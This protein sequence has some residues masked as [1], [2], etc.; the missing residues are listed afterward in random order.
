[1][2]NIDILLGVQGMLESV[3]ESVCASFDN[4]DQ[5]AAYHMGVV[6]TLS[7]LEALLNEDTEDEH[8]EKFVKLTSC[9]SG[10]WQI[11]EVDG[12]KWAAGHSISNVDWLGLLSEHFDAMIEYRVIPDEEMELLC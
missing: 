4:D 8:M 12:K 1:M 3:D 2:N 7:A 5:K 9:E 6:N 11:L 10:D